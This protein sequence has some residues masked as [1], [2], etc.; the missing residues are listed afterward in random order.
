MPRTR[1]AQAIHTALILTAFIVTGCQNSQS[2]L[3]NPFLTPD[4]VPPPSTRALTPGAAQPYYPGDPVPGV[5]AASQPPAYTPAPNYQGSP[6][7]STPGYGTPGATPPGGWN[8]SSQSVPQQT[9]YSPGYGVQPSSAE[10]PLGPT[11]NASQ[12]Y[13]GQMVSAGLDSISIP[14][15]QSRLRFERTTFAEPTQNTLAQNQAAQASYVVPQDSIL[16]TPQ[17]PQPTLAGVNQ[18]TGGVSYLQSYGPANLRPVSQTAYPSSVKTNSDLFA[19]SDGFRPR[20]SSLGQVSQPPVDIAASGSNLF[21]AHDAAQA[22]ANDTA[23][24]FGMGPTYE[25]LRGQL[26]Y[27]PETGQWRIVYMPNGSNPDQLGGNVAVA[28]P[29]LLGQLQSGEFVMVRG[30]LYNLQNDQNAF[31]PVYQLSGVQRQ[32]Q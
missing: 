16:P 7:Q 8:G 4:R 19:G 26:V 9:P 2:A 31:A 22:A 23:T 18:P 11:A 20:G 17:I 14:E 27:S 24:R 21:A 28:N 32:R 1:C 6:Y 3:T 12:N 5:P 29:E 10:I 15:D 13:G 30:Q 25:W